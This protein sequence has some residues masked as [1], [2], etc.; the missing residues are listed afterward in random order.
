[1]PIS[2]AGKSSSRG[3]TLV[4]LA[5]V[6]T[7]LALFAIFTIP[8]F[9]STGTSDLGYSV[10]RL[11][12]AIKYLYNESVLSGQEYRLIFDLERDSYRAVVMEADG[13]LVGAPGMSAD[14]GLS[15]Q[16]T[17]RDLYVPGRGT[18]S[19]GIVTLAIN[20]SGWI[21]EAL[22]HLKADSDEEMT[23]HIMPLTGIAE[24]HDGYHAL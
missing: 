14:I 21:E 22:I 15:G 8:L 4:E 13:E 24:I 19:A 17:F 3:F 16:T 2:K 9:S 5:V 10:R 12:G 11:H 23:L 7:L 6:V 20:P 18:F 1:M